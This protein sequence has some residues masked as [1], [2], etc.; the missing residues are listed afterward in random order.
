M[1]KVGLSVLLEAVVLLSSSSLEGAAAFA[2]L[3]STTTTLTSTSAR[4]W[5]SIGC[6]SSTSNDKQ[7]ASYRNPRLLFQLAAKDDSNKD[8]DSVAVSSSTS[9]PL[10]CTQDDTQQRLGVFFIA[11]GLAVGTAAFV[12]LL[13]ALEHA[14]PNG[15]FDAWRDFTWPLPMGLIFVAA[16]VAH[17][18]LKDTFVEM[19]PPIGTWGG[20]WNVPAPY[21]EKLGLSYA[22]YHTYWTGV[23]EIGGGLLLVGGG[24]GA[25]PVQI[26][27]V[28]LLLLTAAVTPANIYMATHD[29]Q[30]PE[31]PPIPYPEG[32]VARG[33][34]Q[35]VLLG[36]FWKLTFQ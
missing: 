35:C 28:L 7:A 16:G 15:W 30:P 19:V 34:L 11:G 5:A 27:A 4:S 13:T 32:H 10:L 31:L 36:I 20:L 29:V 25:W 14:L 8:N 12:S 9:I 22:E 33:A 26:P 2:P 3:S 21:S 23:A 18:T 1:K 24:L 17:F 6:S